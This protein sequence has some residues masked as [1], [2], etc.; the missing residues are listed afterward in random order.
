M[1]LPNLQAMHCLKLC[2]QASVLQITVV[3][4]TSNVTG[5]NK[6]ESEQCTYLLKVN[7]GMQ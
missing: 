4:K 5:V 1:Q 2:Y 3:S 6:W 7:K